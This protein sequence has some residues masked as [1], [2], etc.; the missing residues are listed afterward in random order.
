MAQVVNEVIVEKKTFSAADGLIAVGMADLL[1]E[2]LRTADA[3]AIVKDAGDRYIVEIEDGITWGDLQKWRPAPGYP[4]VITNEP[5]V[6]AP[7]VGERFDYVAERKKEK[8]WK[9]FREKT[10][11]NKK[12]VSRDM[13]NAPIEPDN[14]LPLYKTYNS[15]RM[16][17]NCLNR[18]YLALQDREELREIV[19]KKLGVLDSY[20]PEAEKLENELMGIPSPLQIFSP[21]SGK[22]IHRPKPDGTTLASFPAK[23]VNW[24]DEWMKYRA[25]GKS[26][27]SFFAGSDGKDTK[28]M[29]LAPGRTSSEIIEKV[30]HELLEMKLYG[31]VKLDIN[32]LLNTADLLI[33]HSKE[34]SEAKGKFALNNNPP[35]KI[36]KGMYSVYFKNLGTASAVMNL[37]F[38]GLPG[39][40]PVTDYQSAQ[41][42]VDILQEHLACINTLNESYSSDVPI[43]LTYRDYLS[44]GDL[45][46]LLEFWTLFGTRFMQMKA[47]NKYTQTFTIKNVRRL[48]MS[49]HLAEI[50]E[51]EGFL[52]ISTAIRKSTINPQMRKAGSGKAPF[53]I[54]YGLAQ[55]WKRKSKHQEDFIK[56]I[57]EFVQRY[58]AP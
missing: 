15:L 14:L 11:A 1:N 58:N 8:V 24:F 56:E 48:L 17:S 10:G 27:L 38:L 6:E 53:E 46:P 36:I 57:S 43:L 34:Y 2:I 47:Q 18:L 9:K 37:S 31:S 45:R 50:V 55:S 49:Y 32:L 30:H 51:N 13:G 44:T 22:G 23:L 42:W 12:K 5:D 25:M 28:L 7:L 33:K 4:Y 35:N 19:G 54:Q 21:V 40:F 52:N 26:M 41:D 20:S 3:E 16:G 39:W 29:V